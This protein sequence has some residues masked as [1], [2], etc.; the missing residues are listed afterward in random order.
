MHPTGSWIQGLLP[1]LPGDEGR[2]SALDVARQRC[3][4]AEGDA[5]VDATVSHL[6]PGEAYGSS[7]IPLYELLRNQFPISNRCAR[8]GSVQMKAYTQNR[9]QE[10][11]TVQQRF[12]LGCVSGAVAHAAFYPLEVSEISGRSEC[13]NIS[14]LTC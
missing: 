10:T 5:T 1:R 12:G 3:Q 7:Q 13:S 8:S 6:R 2:W 4:C 14:V 11:L 9:T